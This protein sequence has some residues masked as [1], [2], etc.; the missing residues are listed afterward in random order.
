MRLW[1]LRAVALAIAVV[2]SQTSSASPEDLF[3]FGPRS[4]AMGGTGA[5]WS[6]GAEAVYTNPALLSFVHQNAITVGFQGASFDLHVDGAGLP[7][8]VS[9]L[10]A[11]G[12]V[13]GVEAPIPF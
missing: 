3:G 10:P 2:S 7:G 11:K 8:R 9:V 6:V 5:A 13:V 1:P 12:W 4:P